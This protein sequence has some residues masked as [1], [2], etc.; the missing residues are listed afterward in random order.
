MALL[1]RDTSVTGPFPKGVLLLETLKGQEELGRP[2]KFDLGLLSKEPDLD[3]A[4]VLGKPLAVCIQLGTGKERFFHG[5]VTRFSKGG[6]TQLYTRY[7]A[8][9]R[10]RLSLLD[11]AAD[12][13]IFNDPA[14][15]ALSIVKTVLA[16]HGLPDVESGSIQDHAYRTRE[17]CVQYRESDLRFV[18][19]LLEEEGIYYFFRHEETKHTLVFADSITAHE[20]ADGYESILYTAKERRV[21]GSEEH[22][23]GLVVRRGLYPGRHTVLSAYDPTQMRPRLPRF[24]RDTSED[25]LTGHEFEHYDYPGGL[26][27]PEEAQQEAT[28]RTRVARVVHIGIDVEGNTMGLGLGNLVSLRPGPD[29]VDGEPFWG[30]KDFDKQ[31]LVVGASYSLSIDQYETG[32]VAFSD[33]PFKAS[34][35]LLDS[36]TQFRPQRRT[37]KPRMAGPQTALV[38][39]PAGEEIWTDKFGR[40][41]VHFDWDRRGERNEKSSCWVRVMQMW[42]GAKWGAQYIPRVGQEVIVAFLDGDPDR[43]VIR[44]HLYNR[45]NMPPYDLPAHQTQSGIKSR[46]SKGGAARNF[47]ELRFEDKKGHEELH[48]QAEKDMSTRVKHDQTLDVGTDRI[49]FVGNDEANLVKNDRQLTVDANDSVV[50]GGTHDKTVT[51]TV[52]QVYGG[53]HSR[54]V[55][56]NQEFFE[57]K[58]KDEHVKQAHK[59][60]T[61]KKFQLNQGATSM[62]FKGTNVTM[63][64]AG[65]ITITA[66]GATVCLDKTGKATF[67]SPTGIKFVCGA[68]TLAVLPGGVAFASPSVTAAAGAGSVVA[69]G[70]EAVAM[71]SKT[72]TVE[73]DGVCTIKGKSA[74]KLQE[75]EGPKGKK[76]AGP[77]AGMGE[78]QGGAGAGAKAITRTQKGAAKDES[79]LEIQV[80]DLNV[81]PQQGLAFRIKMPDGGNT[82]GTL[83]KE[84]RGRAK[85]SRPGVF[86][87]FFPDLDG[88][89][90]DGDGAQELHEE[91]R[92][93]ASSYKV[94]PGDRLTAIAAGHGFL[95]WKTVWDFSGNHHLHMSQRSPSVLI[96]G[97]EI[98]IPT[99]LAR[100]AE[101]EG[102][103][104]RHT[105]HRADDL[106]LR[107][108]LHSHDH[109]YCPTIAYA[110]TLPS[111]EVL[112]GKTDDKGW[113]V[114]SL[115][116]EIESCEIEYWPGGEEQPSVATHVFLTEDI[117]DADQSLLSHLRNL[118]FAEDDEPVKDT[119]LRYQ[120]YMELPTTGTLD[121][122][123]RSSIKKAVHGADASVESELGDD[124]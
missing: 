107:L 111:G 116:S 54:K 94:H 97:D 47:N 25:L 67:D 3:P 84:G 112:K 26:S 24:G 65:T 96:P 98:A 46:S 29:T 37:P 124:E 68:S 43:P 76:P 123:T 80:V 10:P 2:Y 33:E 42:A 75:A 20:T 72:V 92:S 74:L 103:V 15:D 114:C 120:N 55:D 12:C 101:V 56:G 118:G 78:S 85:S 45:D 35:R 77:S 14:Q 11:F 82:S 63:D 8:E 73:A 91:D 5:I 62:T 44:G 104:A 51:G 30:E 21:A 31:Y 52:T 27:K 83:D 9:I 87:V 50:I 71:K 99:R 88:A 60:T 93:E 16:K 113:L 69:M 32:D 66:G 70:K 13:R 100:V 122:T 23:W 79:T 7:A 34:Y 6:A 108:Q 36:H 95:N 1:G 17:F 119:I 121:D 109:K 57:E 106:C 105:V 61:D 64:S 115:F 18:Q 89:D 39:G 48:L 53:D 90:W 117:D 49:I 110:I 4:D 38:V 86:K 81:N 28:A 58:N 40:V 19:R 59:L 41:L 22:F 102:G